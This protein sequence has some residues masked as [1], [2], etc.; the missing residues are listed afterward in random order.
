VNGDAE[1]RLVD[2]LEDARALGLLGP[3]P[4]ARQVEHAAALARAIGAFNGQLLDLGSGGGLPGLVLFSG[5]P[6]S[7]G[8]LLDAQRRRCD[9]LQRAIDAL[10]L[11]DRVEVRCGR[12]E[13]L[14]RDASLRARFDLVVARSFGPPAVTAECAAGFLRSGGSLVVTEPPESILEERWPADGLGRLGFGPA[15]GM[16]EGGTG[17]V[18]MRMSGVA[19][20]RWPRRDGVPGKRPLW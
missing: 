18:R 5:W 14:A 12:A 7:S 17:A 6:G 20:D 19:A 16:R 13:E 10:G 1:Q 8:V 11:A 3:G 4:V 9:F 15:L 2:V